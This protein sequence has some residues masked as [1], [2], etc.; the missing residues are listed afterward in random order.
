[1]LMCVVESTLCCV[2]ACS[3]T[4]IALLSAT[5][6]ALFL[7]ICIR[8]LIIKALVIAT[9]VSKL[10]AQFVLLLGPEDGE[11]FGSTSAS[12]CFLLAFK[13]DYVTT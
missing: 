2:W 11:Q 8:G 10:I 9:S 7:C 1:M 3:E 6:P 13:V 12:R 4:A 5:E